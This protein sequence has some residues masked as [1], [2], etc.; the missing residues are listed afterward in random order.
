MFTDVICKL[1]GFG[2]VTHVRHT[3]LMCFFSGIVYLFGKV[4][5][6][7]AKSHVSCCVAVKNIDKKIFIL[8][9]KYVSASTFVGT[10][11]AESKQFPALP[12]HMF[13]FVFVK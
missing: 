3:S 1:A 9:R 8:P 6:E 2:V 11:Y 7:Q 5:I 10:L 12:A 13:T 4:Y